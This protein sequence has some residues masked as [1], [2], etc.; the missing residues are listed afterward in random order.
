MRLYG[1]NNMF[2]KTNDDLKLYYNFKNNNKKNTL[3]FI[4]GGPGA[5]SYFF[6]K[7]MSEQISK[8]YNLLTYDQR[9][10]GR[11]DGNKNTDYTL[12]TL[13]NDI[14]IIIKK[15]S[16]DNI[17]LLCHSFG[18][19]LGLN[20]IL[21]YQKIK[22]LILLNSTLNFIDSIKYQ[23]TQINKI[24]NIKNE[25]INNNKILNE[26]LK[27]LSILNKENKIH[28][29]SFF[30]YENY[31]NFFKINEIENKEN[32]LQQYV[33]N[34]SEYFKNFNE[35]TDKIHIPVL[36]IN[37]IYDNSVNPNDYKIMK[38]KNLYISNI[39]GS[40][41]LYYENQKEFLNAINHFLN[42]SNIKNETI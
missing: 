31:K 35:K 11:S 30:K 6:E 33:L 26:W 40:H 22:S 41:M 20:Y 36:I 39:K 23:I 12:N 21:K 28:K 32:F 9:G 19:I 2:I 5:S 13:L 3:F 15:L 17:N 42:N 24:L 38:F 1:G 8:N 10:C 4:H 37:G 16:L 27:K 14:D 34:S 29:L 25:T 18:G 7:H